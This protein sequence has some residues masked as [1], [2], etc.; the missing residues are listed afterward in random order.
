MDHAS[1]L[2]DNVHE[3]IDPRTHREPFT[4]YVNGTW[5]TDRHVTDVPPLL[6]QLGTAF[7]RGSSGIGEDKGAYCSQPSLRV[8]AIDTYMRIDT[9]ARN[10]ERSMNLNP[11][12]ELEDV[13]RSLV[14]GLSRLDDDDQD[15]LVGFSSAWVT[16]ARI[17]TGWETPAFKPP[18]TCPLCAKTGG[19]RIRLGDGI[20]SS[21]AHGM[22]VHC[23]EHWTPETIGLLSEHIR[24]ENGDVSGWDVAS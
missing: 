12:Q 15:L 1:K 23:G 21:D 10:W 24:W 6:T 7:Q 3:L 4:K 2:S 22:C 11:R 8:E 13:L 9:E 18:N 14:G 19:L 5:I 16:W 17:A 20:T